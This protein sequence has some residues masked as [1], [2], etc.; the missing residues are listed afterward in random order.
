V[1]V[2]IGSV[3][4]TGVVIVVCWTCLPY[5]WSLPSSTSIS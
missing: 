5:Q 1:G 3:M 4:D 2:E